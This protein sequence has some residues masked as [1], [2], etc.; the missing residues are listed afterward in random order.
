MHI[1][2]IAI[3]IYVLYAISSLILNYGQRKVTDL[4][5]WKVV[6]PCGFASGNSSLWDNSDVWLNAANSFLYRLSES[7]NVSGRAIEADGIHLQSCSGHSLE[8]PA[9]REERLS[10]TNPARSY[11]DPTLHVTTNYKNGSPEILSRQQKPTSEDLFLFPV[12]STNASDS[13]FTSVVTT[14]TNASVVKSTYLHPANS[15]SSTLPTP[16]NNETVSISRGGE[17]VS[18]N[19]SGSDV[20]RSIK[21]EWRGRNRFFSRNHSSNRYRRYD[22]SRSTPG[23]TGNKIND[24]IRDNFSRRAVSP[25]LRDYRPLMAAL[26]RPHTNIFIRFFPRSGTGF[27]NMIRAFRSLL[28]LSISDNFTICLDH[29]AYFSVMNSSLDVL[30]CRNDDK[31]AVWRGTSLDEWVKDSHCNLHFTENRTISASNDYLMEIVRCSNVRSAFWAEQFPC[32]FERQSL[33]R[34]FNH[35]LF[36]PK[37]RII[38]I[39]DRLLAQMTGVRVGLQVR[40]GGNL[41]EFNDTFTFIKKEHIGSVVEFVKSKLHSVTNYTIYL[42]SDTKNAPKL[43]EPLNTTFLVADAF[44][45]GHTRKTNSR[46]LERAVLDLYVLSKCDILFITWLSSYGHLARDL[47]DSKR[48]Y[49]IK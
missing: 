35:F 5:E 41:A 9:G 3:C 47:S 26:T 37:Q 29:P 40:F 27:G 39:G 18:R 31:Y 28:L 25:N 23:Y 24:A 22:E 45:I 33:A 13:P 7:L 14:Y 49:T 15:V 44:E 17:L 10:S 30:R 42:S 34:Y 11:V 8:Q 16:G 43:L 4:L 12:A 1:G 2:V 36:Q 46:F 19:K 6:H 20:L 38:D 21:G 32:R 48:V